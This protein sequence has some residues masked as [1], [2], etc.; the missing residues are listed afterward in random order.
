[1]KEPAEPNYN[2]SRANMIHEPTPEQSMEPT[3][4]MG[5]R[6]SRNKHVLSKSINPNASR[7]TWKQLRFADDYS[8]TRDVI[9]TYRS[10]NFK[11]LM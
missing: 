5:H 9:N 4:F 10:I 8:K 7:A 1:M 11:S 2:T 6:G 3:S